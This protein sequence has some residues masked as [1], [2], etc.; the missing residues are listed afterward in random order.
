MITQIGDLTTITSMP[1]GAQLVIEHSNDA[2]LIGVDSLISALLADALWVGTQAEYNELGTY[3]S[4]TLYVIVEIVQ[5][6][7]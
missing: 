4:T 1:V 6:G 5:Q 3:N 2:N 7:S